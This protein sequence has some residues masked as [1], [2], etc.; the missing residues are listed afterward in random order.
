MSDWSNNFY[1]GDESP[2]GTVAKDLGLRLVGEPTRGYQEDVPRG[3]PWSL[4][5]LAQGKETD[6]SELMYGPFAGVSTQ[7]FRFNLVTYRDDSSN[8]ARSCL[9]FAFDAAFPTLSIHP[10][11]RLSLAQERDKS[12]FGQRY[13]V[14]GHDPDVV[15]L[16]LSD[17]LRVWLSRLTMPLRLELGGG[18]L[19]G[20]VPALPP[21]KL[22]NLVQTMYR[23][24]LQIP[25]E[26]WNRFGTGARTN[27]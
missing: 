17:D 15:K 6:L 8:P 23:I 7:V 12:P 27:E 3:L 9:V 18:T 13:R 5:L 14:L 19:L 16:V 25:D 26:A 1:G 10:H 21:E 2:L 4:P 22:A 20:H 24:Y 11:N